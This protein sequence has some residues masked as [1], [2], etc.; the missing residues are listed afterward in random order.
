MYYPPPPSALAP[1]EKPYCWHATSKK[2]Q[3]AS[4]AKSLTKLSISADDD[5]YWKRLE[6]LEMK[7]ELD[8]YLEKSGQ[9]V[10][11]EDD[12][13][14]DDDDDDEEDD[15]DELESDS[16]EDGEDESSQSHRGTVHF[17]DEGNSRLLITRDRFTFES[18]IIQ[19]N[20]SL[21]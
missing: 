13:D 18:I 19:K 5:E 15:D 9:A 3:I 20:W 8:E 7:E 14:D 1:A 4:C 10:A 21:S 2:W 16:D 6:E 12:V 17:V 11:S